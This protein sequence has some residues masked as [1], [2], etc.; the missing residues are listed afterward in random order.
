MHFGNSLT[1]KQSHERNA[2]PKC[3]FESP[4]CDKWE[5]HVLKRCSHA[6]GTG[7]GNPD[8]S[9]SNVGRLTQIRTHIMHKATY[10]AMPALYIAYSLYL[11]GRVLNGR[12]GAKTA[13]CSSF[14]S[15]HWPSCPWPV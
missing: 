2:S 13:H 4:V 5:V 10:C 9:E 7:V 11:S 15:C 8:T 3:G 1:P 6:V 12:G 14:G